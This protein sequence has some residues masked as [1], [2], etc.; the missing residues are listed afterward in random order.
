MDETG[1]ETT[2]E[3][4]LRSDERRFRVVSIVAAVLSLPFVAGHVFF[5]L[6]Q[7][8]VFEKMFTDMGGELPAATQALVSL[9]H[10]GILALL[11]VAID[12]AVFAFFY[13]LA[14]RYWIGL[15]FAPLFLYF[16]LSGLFIPLLYLPMF[17]II[18]LVQ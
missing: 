1:P 18:T 5:A 6:V 3:R 17:N 12:V 16:V 11:L 15:L 9:S 2:R 14:K 4:D 7:I 8:P 10:Y 13:W